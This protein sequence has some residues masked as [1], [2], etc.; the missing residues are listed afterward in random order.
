MK[1]SKKALEAAGRDYYGKWKALP[2]DAPV[3]AYANL[4][5]DA[6]KGLTEDERAFFL[7]AV[8][9]QCDSQV[10]AA[11]TALNGRVAGSDDR[12]GMRELLSTM[13]DDAIL[14]AVK[15]VARGCGWE[16]IVCETGEVVAVSSA[17][18]VAYGFLA[19]V[20]NGHYTCYDTDK[21][22][23]A[24]MCKMPGGSCADCGRAGR[25][26]FSCRCV[27][28]FNSQLSC[29]VEHGWHVLEANAEQLVLRVRKY[30]WV[31]TLLP[32]F[33]GGDDDA[34]YVFEVRHSGQL[35]PE[36]YYSASHIVDLESKEDRK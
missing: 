26:V 22:E 25:C 6:W 27:T 29:F 15:E 7:R 14:Q 2:K 11:A 18:G 32:P 9:V 21:T 36:L 12:R 28:C 31:V 30:D 17:V 19:A 1:V 16:R 35:A 24:A 20:F 5:D 3:S 23:K 8:R 13:E 34:G 10:V 4:W 33:E